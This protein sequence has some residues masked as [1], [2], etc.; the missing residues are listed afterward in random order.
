MLKNKINLE[1][2]LLAERSKF[3]SQTDLIEEVS[4]ILHENEAARENIKNAL[5]EKSSTEANDFDINLLETD[6]IFHLVQIRLVCVDYRLRFLDTVYFKDGIPEEAITKIHALEKA[7]GTTL[8][9]FKIMAPSKAFQLLSYDDPLLFAP[10]GNDYYYLVHQW[11]KD[12]TPTRKWLVMPFKNLLNF[13][14]FSVVVSLLITMLTPENN[15][16]KA[17]PMANII[18]FLFAFKSIVAVF[19]YAFFMMGKNFNVAIWDRKYFNN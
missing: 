11:G 13:I 16:S 3:K 1:Q 14:L 8:G 9:G 7:H 17:V 6:K 15:L 19:M 5:I 4:R 2:E 10:I 12:I 18:I